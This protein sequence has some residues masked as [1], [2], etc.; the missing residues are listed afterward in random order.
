MAFVVTPGT[1][2][3]R[4]AS[5]HSE[6]PRIAISI[7]GRLHGSD[8]HGGKAQW[9]P[10]FSPCLTCISLTNCCCEPNQGPQR[11]EPKVVSQPGSRY[12]ASQLNSLPLSASFSSSA[13]VYLLVRSCQ[14]PT[15]SK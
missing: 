1:S 5:G 8:D 12:R 14:H 2:W 4:Q 6:M 13:K 11:K 7:V 9:K 15:M 10:T 3:R